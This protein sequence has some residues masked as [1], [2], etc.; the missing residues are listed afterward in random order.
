MKTSLP[1]REFLARAAVAGSALAFADPLASFAAEKAPAKTFKI[2]AFSKPFTKLNFEDAADLVADIGWD[3]IEC[4]VRAKDAH[5]QPERVEEDLPKLVAALKKRGKEVGIVTSDITKLNPQAEKVLR[6]MARLGLKRYR[7][8]FE[9][10]PKDE[11]PAKKIAEVG[12]ALKDIAALNKELG[13]QGGWQNHSGTDYVGAPIWDVWTMERDLDP[14][15]IGICFDIGHAT[16][17]GGKCWPVQARLMEPFLVAVYFKDF[18]W[19]K[20]AKGWDSHWCNLGQGTVQKS[21]VDWLK[22][23]SFNGPLSQHHEYKDLG[24]GKEM[25]ANFKKDLATLKAWLA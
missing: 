12:A 1:R 16:L 24:T 3:G 20:T 2:I 14:K 6:T 9:K 8:G 23:S 5:I 15:H 21:F 4:G 18:Y 13:L 11:S 19:E 25:I 17:E 22:K 7:L 10:Y